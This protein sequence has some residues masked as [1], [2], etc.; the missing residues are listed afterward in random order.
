MTILHEDLSFYQANL[1][2]L[3]E[4]RENGT[5]DL[6]LQGIFL[7]AET[8][9][10]NGR[11][12]PL[13]TIKGAVETIKDKIKNGESVLGEA[14]HPKDLSL[15]ISLDRVSHDITS[16]WMEGNFGM[17]KMKILPT[18]MGNIIRAMLESNV[19]LG[20]SSRGHGDTDSNNVV[21]KYFITTVDIVAQPSAQSAYPKTIYEGL[22]RN[23][24]TSNVLM[25][26]A[27]AAKYDPKAREY[28]NL[29][30]R[31]IIESL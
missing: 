28:L 31:K 26:L 7:Q 3:T 4:D 19:K 21:T 27:E 23:D 22:L 12:Y 25:E 1:N 29:G 17:G 11:I 24:K 16:M 30:V 2:V 9:N 15:T 20:V 8:R 14:D 6:Y 5:K 10:Q 18:P 13:S